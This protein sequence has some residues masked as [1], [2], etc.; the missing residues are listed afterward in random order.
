[1]NLCFATSQRGGG[2]IA[3][4]LFDAHLLT[5]DAMMSAISEVVQRVRAGSLTNRMLSEGT[6]TLTSLG[7]LGVEGILPV[8][9]PPQV[10]IVGAGAVVEKPRVKDG[11]VVVRPLMT[12]AL[13][14]DHRVS[15]GARG[16]RFLQAI[17][18]N[19]QQPEK[20]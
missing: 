7:D 9:Q 2:L 8:I 14:A 13:G 15:D 17:G 19:L 1:V 12:L 3:P 18:K 16:A 4:A 5:I 11:A 10:A 20:P 6:I